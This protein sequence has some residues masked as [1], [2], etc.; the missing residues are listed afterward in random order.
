MFRLIGIDC[1]LYS[2]LSGN[3]SLNA[4]LQNFPLIWSHNDSCSGDNGIKNFLKC[5]RICN[6]VWTVRILQK[7]SP[8]WNEEELVL[9]KGFLTKKN[10]CSHEIY[11]ISPCLYCWRIMPLIMIFARA[12]RLRF[13]NPRSLAW[14]L[15]CFNHSI[16][17]LLQS[18]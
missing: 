10:T 11:Y 16:V 15:S 13:H 4:A 7:M 17:S 1:I 9:Y 8:V 6:H 14:Y 5:L 12:F 18:A 3:L 2:W